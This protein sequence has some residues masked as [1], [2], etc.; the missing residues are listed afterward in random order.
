L[1]NVFLADFRQALLTILQALDVANKD[2]AIK[3]VVSGF[4]PQVSHI[5]TYKARFSLELT[6]DFL[7]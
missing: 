1:Q 4:N 3:H 6:N 2:G 5:A 7:W